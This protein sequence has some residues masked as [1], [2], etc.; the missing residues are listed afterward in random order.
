[1]TKLDVLSGFKEIPVCVAYEIDGKQT[2]EIPDTQT[3]F[4]HA[5]PVYEY[6]PGWSEDISKARQIEDL[7]KNAQKYLEFLEKASN[8]PISA[9]GVGQHRDAV[10]SIRDLIN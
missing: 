2:E 4:H 5:K 3:E 6:L 9:V 8:A 7:P 10:I 1:V